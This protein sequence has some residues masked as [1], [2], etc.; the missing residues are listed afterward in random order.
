MT[1]SFAEGVERLSREA[2]NE[3]LMFLGNRDAERMAASWKRVRRTLVAPYGN[4]P[5]DYA[6]MTDW[7]WDQVTFSFD[8]WASLAQIPIQK[9]KALGR[10]LM[11]NHVVLPDGTVPSAVEKY[12]KGRVV[13]LLKQRMKT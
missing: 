6:D 4:S 9:A 13:A 1:N 10:S 12:L 8:D 2:G 3:P 11:M 7:L 5:D